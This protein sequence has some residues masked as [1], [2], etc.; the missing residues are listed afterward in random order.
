M[1]LWQ[2]GLCFFLFLS[3]QP[4]NAEEIRV[5]VASGLDKIHISADNLKIKKC[6]RCPSE[7]WRNQKLK[8]Q[9]FNG[10]WMLQS[11]SAKTKTYAVESLLL[12]GK[13]AFDTRR[14]P[15]KLELF[16]RKNAIDVVYSLDLEDY[17]RGVLPSEMPMHWP[18]D[19]LKAQAIASRTYVLMQ[20]KQYPSRYYH[21]DNTVMD[22][23][24]HWSHQLHP[25]L[26]KKLDQVIQET[27]SAFLFGAKQKLVATY[28]H[29]HCG[30][31]T[32]K[33]KKVWGHREGSKPVKDPYC[34]LGTN[35]NW[36]YRIGKQELNKAYQKYS[37]DS[38][39]GK[40]ISVI[41]GKKNISGRMEYISLIFASGKIRRWKSQELRAS[42]GFTKL[43]STRFS[44]YDKKD[45]YLFTGNGFGHGVGLC[46][47]GAKQMASLGYNFR[48][49]LKHYY[50][51]SRI[52]NF[53]QRVT[54]LQQ[55]R[56]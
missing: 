32:E 12:Q 47:H 9:V 36:F 17:I 46:Q 16:A 34:L 40:L 20:K 53:P 28:F 24:F 56:K 49:I 35:K 51:R 22:Q 44:F 3:H 18:L 6:H 45:H 41:P 27:R 23:V 10:V 55:R 31:F 8:L 33:A 1:K 48:Q 39:L 52:G 54:K 29:S 14:M 42:L 30:G 19:S 21:V 50:P 4:G 5:R 25:K 11:R 15:N 26:E 13:F 43:K 38:R 2:K 7:L 37:K